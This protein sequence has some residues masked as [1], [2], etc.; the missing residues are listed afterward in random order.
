MDPKYFISAIAG[1]ILALGAYL[2]ISDEVAPASHDG[3]Q[4]GTGL[5]VIT[6]CREASSV[7]RGEY[8]KD[9][10]GVRYELQ[11]GLEIVNWA[12]APIGKNFIAA[13][14]DA[15]GEVTPVEVTTDAVQCIYDRAEE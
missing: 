8:D 7:T 13:H 1:A 9:I 2:G 4:S 14:Y 5:S 12:D 15:K 10:E 11:R 3:P 6:F